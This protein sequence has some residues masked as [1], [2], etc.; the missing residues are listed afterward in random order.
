MGL[1]VAAQT[2][3]D[4]GRREV[5]L[6]RG[7]LPSVSPWISYHRSPV[8]IWHVG[9][10]FKRDRTGCNRSPVGR[11]DILNIDIQKCRHRLAKA[12]AAAHHHDGIADPDFGRQ[13]VTEFATCL[14]YLPDK[15]DQVFRFTHDNARRDGVPPIRLKCSHVGASEKM[16]KALSPERRMSA[17][18]RPIRRSEHRPTSG[19]APA[20]LPDGGTPSLCWIAACSFRSTGE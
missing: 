14:K 11:I 20:I 2:R 15:C 19:E 8:A 7:N 17:K 6:M 13:S 18:R 16:R 1:S 10:R 12:V 5:A 3:T 9:R 4:L